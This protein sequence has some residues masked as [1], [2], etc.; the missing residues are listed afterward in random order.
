MFFPLIFLVKAFED[1]KKKKREI[2]L[3]QFFNTTGSGGFNLYKKA[4]KKKW[5]IGGTFTEE[6]AGRLFSTAF[7]GHLKKILVF[8]QRLQMVQT[9][10]R[11][12]K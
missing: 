3:L 12:N 10:R 1:D 4:C 11:E 5:K 9:G 7:L 8:Y 2:E 6:N